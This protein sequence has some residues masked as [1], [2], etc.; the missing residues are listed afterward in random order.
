VQPTEA[1]RLK[2][3]IKPGDVIWTPPGVKHWHGGTDT[4]THIAVQDS[5]DGQPVDWLEH[6]PDEQYLQ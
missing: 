1:G 3:S 5:V 2:Q 6:V 4:T